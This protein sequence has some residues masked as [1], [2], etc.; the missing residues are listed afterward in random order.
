M[1]DWHT[2]SVKVCTQSERGPVGV[3][4]LSPIQP[5]GAPRR[6]TLLLLLL[7][8]S[9]LFFSFIFYRTSS[10]RS[11]RSPQLPPRVGWRCR[12]HLWKEN[13]DIKS[14]TIWIASSH[15]HMHTVAAQVPFVL[16]FFPHARL[17][18]AQSFRTTYTSDSLL[19]SSGSCPR[20]SDATQSSCI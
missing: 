4:V 18:I 12:G 14:P 7:T 17:Q 5:G 11:S 9:I 10:F 16:F 6:G 20:F 2:V 13:W 3:H 15:M 1:V 8:L 19:V